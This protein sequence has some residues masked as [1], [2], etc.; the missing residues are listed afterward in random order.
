M[1]EELRGAQIPGSAGAP[2]PQAGATAQAEPAATTTPPDAGAEVLYAGKYKT[3]DELEKAYL[4]LRKVMAQ[5]GP[6]T[7][8]PAGEGRAVQPA[9]PAPAGQSWEQVNEDF[10]Q[11][12]EQNPLGTVFQ[13]IQ[14]Y[15]LPQQEAASQTAVKMETYRLAAQYPEEFTELQP[16][17]GRL[18]GEYPYLRQVVHAHPEVLELL[19]KTVRSDLAGEAVQAAKEAGREEGAQGQQARAGGVTAPASARKEPTKK[20]PQEQLLDELFGEQQKKGVFG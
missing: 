12:F 18:L 2:Q 20:T 7:E 14:T 10:R 3:P 17:I 13:L 19:F 1:L 9:Q 11:A 8:M 6:I 16:K 5:K 4:G 15:L